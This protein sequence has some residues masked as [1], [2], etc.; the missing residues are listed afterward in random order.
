MLRGARRPPRMGNP[1]RQYE[2]AVRRVLH[3]WPGILVIDDQP[4]IRDLFREASADDGH[5]V[6]VAAA[7]YEGVPSCHDTRPDW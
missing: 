4:N 5:H 7:G 2:P 6:T 1:P 3:S